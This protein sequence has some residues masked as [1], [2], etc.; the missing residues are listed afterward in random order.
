[1]VYGWDPGLLDKAAGFVQVNFFDYGKLV[2]QGM[3]K[4]I[5]SGD[6][7]IITGQPGRAEIKQGSDGFREGFGD[8]SRV[9]AEVPGN[10]SRQKAFDQTKSLMTKYPNLKGLYVQND[11]M[12]IGAVKALGPK[13][14]D[15]VV[16]SM[17]GSPEGLKEFEQGNIKVLSGNSIPIEEGQAVRY[18][19][20]AINGT[21]LEPRVCY[22]QIGLVEDASTWD[23]TWVPSTEL[24]DKGIQQPCANSK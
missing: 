22:T 21:M 7:A 1:M 14:K 17:N 18:L 3:K 11:D 19:A 23:M 13:I 20:S 4:L 8:N 15:V 16:G 6:V 24:V 2:G 10:W 12:A 9:V 5:P